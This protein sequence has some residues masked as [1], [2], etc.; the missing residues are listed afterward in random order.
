MLKV[1]STENNLVVLFWTFFKISRQ[2][3]RIRKTETTKIFC[4][5]RN[6]FL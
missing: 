5:F 6:I 4:W 3:R 2:P 1:L